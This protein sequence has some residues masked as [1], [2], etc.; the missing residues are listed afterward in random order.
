MKHYSYLHKE[1]EKSL[2]PPFHVDKYK[3]DKD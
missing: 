2:D 3:F 1:K